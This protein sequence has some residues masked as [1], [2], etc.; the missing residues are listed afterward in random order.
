MKRFYFYKT[1]G[2]NNF[3]LREESEDV[4]FFVFLYTDDGLFKVRLI[5]G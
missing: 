5:K 2:Q 1:Y 4:G 3:G